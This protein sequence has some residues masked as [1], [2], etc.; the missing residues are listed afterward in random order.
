MNTSR[1]EKKSIINKE[2]FEKNNTQTC[3][4]LVCNLCVIFNDSVLLDLHTDTIHWT[5]K[6]SKEINI[7]G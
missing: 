7:K 1:T 2:G 6:K 4:H 3:S 5:N